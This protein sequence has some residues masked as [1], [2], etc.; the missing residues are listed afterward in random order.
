MRLGKFEQSRFPLYRVA[1]SR[2]V[3]SYKLKQTRFSL[4]RVATSLVVDSNQRQRL[5]AAKF[6]K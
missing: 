6:R 5:S 1:T 3:D 2:I 4:Y